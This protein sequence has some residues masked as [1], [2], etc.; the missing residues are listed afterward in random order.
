MKNT[1][2]VAFYSLTILSGLLSI[3][4]FGFLF[5]GKETIQTGDYIICYD[6]SCFEVKGEEEF[7]L[8]SKVKFVKFKMWVKISLD[9]EEVT[10]P[11]CYVYDITGPITSGRVFWSPIKNKFI[12]IDSNYRYPCFTG[13][14][15]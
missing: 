3:F 8:G 12:H 5:Y 15:N 10:Y 1:F 2:K 11:F 6:D 13:P 9:V 14:P 7:L 4:F